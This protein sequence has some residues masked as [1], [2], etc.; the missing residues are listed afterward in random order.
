ML[1]NG[2]WL[3]IN[4]NTLD[5]INIYPNPSNGVITISTTPSN[6]YIIKAIDVLGN[7]VYSDSKIGKSSI[8]LSSFGAGIYIIQLSNENS[9]SS[10]RVVIQ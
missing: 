5:N 3:A 2:G 6:S 8:D 7:V 10:K 4:E 1:M 9:T